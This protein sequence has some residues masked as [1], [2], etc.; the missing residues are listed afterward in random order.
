LAGLRDQSLGQLK[1]V[2]CSFCAII[3]FLWNAEEVSQG[4]LETHGKDIISTLSPKRYS[5]VSQ[6]SSHFENLIIEEREL[7]LILSTSKPISMAFL[8]V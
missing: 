4:H 2:V 5:L 7:M 6:S 8:K 1:I 3:P